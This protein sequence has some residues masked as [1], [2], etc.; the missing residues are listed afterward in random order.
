MVPLFADVDDQRFLP[1]CAI[2]AAPAN[3]LLGCI[4]LLY[5][6][7]CLCVDIHVSDARGAVVLPQ[8]GALGQLSTLD[9]SIP[10]FLPYMPSTGKGVGH[11]YTSGNDS[12]HLLPRCS[13]RRCTAGQSGRLGTDRSRQIRQREATFNSGKSFYTAAHV[14]P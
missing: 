7:G 6:I 3:M 12:K 5:D 8:S 4:S 14:A 11:S 9:S 1:R 2:L 13:G 10:K